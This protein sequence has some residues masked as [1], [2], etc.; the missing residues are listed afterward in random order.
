MGRVCQNDKSCG[1]VFRSELSSNL[2]DGAAILLE[3]H[4]LDV[5][6]WAG[7]HAA[8]LAREQRMTL[9]SLAS[10]PRLVTLAAAQGLTAIMQLGGL[11]H[12]VSR[13]AACYVYTS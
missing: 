4:T 9:Q 8:G 10:C 7:H 11:Q 6:D 13:M 1:A 12:D 3:S 5:D 2:K